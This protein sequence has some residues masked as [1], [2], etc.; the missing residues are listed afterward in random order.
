M[1]Y[2]SERLWQVGWLVAWVLSLA[3]I[4]GCA[5]RYVVTLPADAWTPEN[6]R[7]VIVLPLLPGSDLGK[8]AEKGTLKSGRIAPDAADR[9]AAQMVQILNDKGYRVIPS[10]ALGISTPAVSSNLTREWILGFWPKV[11]ADTLVTVLPVRYEDRVGGPAGVS[12]PASVAFELKIYR[13]N[14][15]TQVWQGAYGETQRSLFEDVGTLPLFIKRHGQWLTAE[16]LAMY[17]ATELLKALPEIS[18]R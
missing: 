15:G 1:R 14:D 7:N 11:G 10:D 2:P 18:R 5:P 9:I 4:S 16:E 12:S 17:G 13:I 6:V 3:A 8:G